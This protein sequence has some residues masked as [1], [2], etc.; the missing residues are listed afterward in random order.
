MMKRYALLTSFLHP[1]WGSCL[2]AAVM[3]LK[4]MNDYKELC[5][6]DKPFVLMFYAPWC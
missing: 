1:S 3:E 5:A 2:M 6:Q 4:T